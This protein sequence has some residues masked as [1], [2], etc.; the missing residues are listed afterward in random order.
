L[1][2]AKQQD[3]WTIQQTE[4]KALNDSEV[5]EISSIELK[6]LMIRMVTEVKEDVNYASMKSKRISI[7]S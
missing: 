6:R 2:Q 1:E 4:I 7:N 3:L 5:D